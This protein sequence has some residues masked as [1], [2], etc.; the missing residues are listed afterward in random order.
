MTLTN[1]NIMGGRSEYPCAD[2]GEEWE[3]GD[4]V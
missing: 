4:A 2:R 1:V 3:G